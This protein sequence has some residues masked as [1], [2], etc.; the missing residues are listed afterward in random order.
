MLRQNES[1]QQEHM[2]ETQP[3]E[4]IYIP[5][6]GVRDALG[7][8]GPE[9]PDFWRRFRDEYTRRATLVNR[10]AVRTFANVRTMLSSLSAE[11]T[12]ACTKF[13]TALASRPNFSGR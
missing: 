4:H 3:L 11:V 10:F 9:S 13:K 7:S 1:A 5:G 2:T 6:I 8:D 12:S